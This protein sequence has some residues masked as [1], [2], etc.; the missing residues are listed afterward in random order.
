MYRETKWLIS[1]GNQEKH[2]RHWRAR[3]EPRAGLLYW[4]SLFRNKRYFKLVYL[5]AASLHNPF[6]TLLSSFSKNSWFRS[7][8]Y[9]SRH[10]QNINWIPGCRCLFPVGTIFILSRVPRTQTNNPKRTLNNF[11][12]TNI[13][14]PRNSGWYCDRWYSRFLSRLSNFRSLFLKIKM[15]PSCLYQFENAP[16]LK[17]CKCFRA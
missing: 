15:A 17:V 7:E 16:E 12:I 14:C 9:W 2:F 1:T 10:L 3:F 13:W 11:R 5:R 6:I 8:R 4:G